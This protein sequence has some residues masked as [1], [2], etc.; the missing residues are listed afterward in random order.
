MAAA[1]L[2]SLAGI[3]MTHVPYKGATLA[4]QDLVGGRL[5]LMLD[6]I[7]SSIGFIRNGR[8][9]ALAVTP[10]KRTAL[11]PDVPTLAESGVPGYEFTAW[12]MILAPA[13][14]PASDRR[15]LQRRAAS[16]GA[17][18]VVS[19]AT[20]ELRRRSRAALD[21]AQNRRVP[22]ARDRS[23]GRKIVKEANIKCNE[24]APHG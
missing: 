5:E 10:A 24:Q 16:S 22:S 8:L 15:A 13:K 18:R 12:W 14:T 23:A 2:S 17:R 7:P 6:Q 9:R 1:M 19:R 11:L 4:L 21:A 3:Q 20:G